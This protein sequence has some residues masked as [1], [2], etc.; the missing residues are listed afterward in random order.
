MTATTTQVKSQFDFWK[1]FV[2]I[3]N[4]LMK[5]L[6]ASPLH[7]LVSDWYMLISVTGKKTGHV[8]TTPVQYKQV[9]HRLTIIS[10]KDYQWWKNLR[11][12]AEVQVNLQGQAH[13][14]YAT[15]SD[16]QKDVLAAYDALYPNMAKESRDKMAG[17]SIVIEVELL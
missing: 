6:L 10:S 11:S 7:F 4:P 1:F 13:S 15:V 5:W 16:T 14:A 9:A 2:R 8:Y 3:Q 17:N 12:G